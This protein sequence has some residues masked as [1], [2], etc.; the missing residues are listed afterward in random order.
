MH[1]APANTGTGYWW[2]WLNVHIDLCSRSSVKKSVVH[3]QR[4]GFGWDWWCEEVVVAT[5][6]PCPQ[7][8]PLSLS[9]LQVPVLRF[10]F[11]LSLFIVGASTSA[12]RFPLSCQKDQK[13]PQVTLT[14]LAR[15]LHIWV[16]YVYPVLIRCVTYWALTIYIC[17]R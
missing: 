6:T 15:I 16:L 5:G 8:F 14:Y 2:A 1:G 11:Y 4:R 10:S 13:Q 12:C 7:V 9:S 3:F 17:E